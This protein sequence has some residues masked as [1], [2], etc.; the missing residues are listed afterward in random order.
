MGSTKAEAR[1]NR[2]KNNMTTC[3]LSK[4]IMKG[5]LKQPT[6]QSLFMDSD[7]NHLT[8]N[9]SLRAFPILH[10]RSHIFVNIPCVKGSANIIAVYNLIF[11]FY[12]LFLLFD[13]I[14]RK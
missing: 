6:E 4:E 12:D 2:G 8:H 5:I 3:I 13:I 10:A 9:E 1:T 7:T 14:I 11:A